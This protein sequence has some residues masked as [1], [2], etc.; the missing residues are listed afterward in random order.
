[1]NNFAAL[2]IGSALTALIANPAFAAATQSADSQQVAPAATMVA[3]QLPAATP[4]PAAATTAPAASPAVTVASAP[5]PA[6]E[7]VAVAKEQPVKIGYIDLS[8][9]ASGSKTGKAAAASL[10]AKS[11]ALKSKIEAKQKQ[12]EKQKVAIEAKLSTMSAAERAT[13]SKEFQ[14]KI[15][16]FQKL[17]RSSEEEMMRMQDK[18]TTDI[19]KD[20]KKSSASYAKSHGYTAVIDEKAILYMTDSVDSDDLTSEISELLDAQQAKKKK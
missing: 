12:I 3:A 9:I 8:K 1:M 15:E 18:L 17:V 7:S 2:L 6:S 19:T 5:A 14:K 10:K 20:I 16:D 13:K 4:A 11:A